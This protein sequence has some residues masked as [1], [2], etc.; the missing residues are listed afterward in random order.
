MKI[1][2][3]VGL[4]IFLVSINLSGVPMLCERWR[5]LKHASNY[6]MYELVDEHD[7][8][9]QETSILRAKKHPSFRET[10]DYKFKEEEKIDTRGFPQLFFTLRDK[11]GNEFWSMPAYEK[12]ICRAFAVAK[13]GISVIHE[14][15]DSTKII[16]LDTH[17]NILNSFVIE[18]NK[19]TWRTPIKDGEYWM[20]YS[21]YNKYDE[22][23]FKSDVENPDQSRLYFFDS[24]G[25]LLNQVLLKYKERYS[26]TT[27]SKNDDMIMFTCYEDLPRYQKK[28]HSYYFRFDGS[29]IGEY[30]NRILGEGKFSEDESL[31]LAFS[32]VVVDTETGEM[33]IYFRSGGPS[34]IS[35]QKES[36]LASNDMGAFHIVNLKTKEVLFYKGFPYPDPKYIEISGDGKEVIVLHQ[37]KFYKFR[38]K[39]NIVK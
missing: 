20:V 7:L 3:L 8:T 38:M 15:S 30:E 32:N 11:D 31:F 35:N 39:S 12:G 25:N 10:K 4:I 17:G 26:E 22:T 28:Y 1:T 16:W 36:I 19:S 27:Y 37:K 5:D 33:L 21:F 13:N 34:V 29:I 6:P 9:D 2:S 18:K 24:A 23:I 14:F